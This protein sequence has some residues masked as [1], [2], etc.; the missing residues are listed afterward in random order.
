MLGVLS[1]GIYWVP[2][3]ELVY[4]GDLLASIVTA[5]IRQVSKAHGNFVKE[6]STFYPLTSVEVMDFESGG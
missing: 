5:S 6:S 1:D 3:I 4:L 2:H